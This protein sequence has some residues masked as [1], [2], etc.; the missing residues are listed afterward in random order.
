[1]I[2]AV[3]PK[4]QSQTPTSNAAG[5]DTDASLLRTIAP[6]FV[7]ATD[8]GTPPKE[9]FNLDRTVIPSDLSREFDGREYI[10]IQ[11]PQDPSA[12]SQEIINASANKFQRPLGDRPQTIIDLSKPLTTKILTQGINTD[13]PSSME[14]IEDDKDETFLIREGLKPTLPLQDGAYRQFQLSLKKIPATY[15]N[16][17]LLVGE[18]IEVPQGLKKALDEALGWNSVDNLIEHITNEFVED[19]KAEKQSLV[20]VL[21]DSAKQDLSTLPSRLLELLKSPKTSNNET[22]I[23]DLI[24]ATFTPKMD[25]AI[26]RSTSPADISIFNKET[27][28]YQSVDIN[29]DPLAPTNEAPIDS[30]SDANLDKTVVISSPAPTKVTPAIFFASKGQLE[31]HKE[32]IANPNREVTNIDI[33]IIDLLEIILRARVTKAVKDD[34]F[35]G[36]LVK[37]REREGKWSLAKKIGLGATAATLSIGIPSWAISSSRSAAIKLA[38][39]QEL[40]KET[41]A[42]LKQEQLASRAKIEIKEAPAPLAIRPETIKSFDDI[43]N[44]TRLFKVSELLADGF[45]FSKPDEQAKLKQLQTKLREAVTAIRNEN[46]TN[47]DDLMDRIFVQWADPNAVNIHDKKEGFAYSNF[48]YKFK[49]KAKGGDNDFPVLG[50]IT[51]PYLIRLGK[52]SFT[53]DQEAIAQNKTNN[54]APT[55]RV[56]VVPGRQEGTGQVVQISNSVPAKQNITNI[57]L[58]L[59]PANAPNVAIYSNPEFFKINTAQPMN[60]MVL[61]IKRN[62]AINQLGNDPE[63]QSVLKGTRSITVIDLDEI[64]PG[65]IIT[66]PTTGEQI[67]LLS[68][69]NDKKIAI[70]M[71]NGKGNNGFT[72]IYDTKFAKGLMD[73]FKESQVEEQNKTKDPE[74]YAKYSRSFHAQEKLRIAQLTTV[75]KEADTASKESPLRAVSASK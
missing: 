56:I 1:M 62:I 61:N 33:A 28:K 54:E 22:K 11:G 27:G 10:N 20:S 55:P 16:Q 74:N 71:N 3:P 60:S 42:E 2:Q 31:E 52:K 66:S 57:D 53:K 30:N 47:Q 44:E 32:R 70:G 72:L 13:M 36:I 6:A 41:E 18:K 48:P 38:Q 50:E 63:A 26:L 15:R 49:L 40:Q 14:C 12:L 51:N 4:P 17:S 19:I 69:A 46:K 23:W 43:W 73:E 21:I 29:G 64:K 45:I 75:L 39:Q 25:Q 35:K 9:N 34:S 68:R 65:D 5:G 58:Q 8:N 24:S 37:A 7:P 59:I 67:T